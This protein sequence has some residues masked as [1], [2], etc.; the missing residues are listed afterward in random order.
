[1]SLSLQC[2]LVISCLAM[3]LRTF[4]FLFCTASKSMLVDLSIFSVFKSKQIYTIF[5]EFFLFIILVSLHFG[6]P[7]IYLSFT[8]QFCKIFKFLTDNLPIMWPIKSTNKYSLT[9]DLKSNSF[10]FF[11]RH[12]LNKF[13]FLQL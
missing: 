3:F 4:I 1:M 9:K 12:Y 6:V 5:I 10:L 13:L 2:L 7:C 11:I 8:N